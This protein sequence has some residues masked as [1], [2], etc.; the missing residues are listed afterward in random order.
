MPARKVNGLSEIIKNWELLCFDNFI[1]S[2]TYDKI[3]EKVLIVLR[4]NFW[5][6][7]TLLFLAIIFT[8]KC[9][10]KFHKLK[11]LGCEI[12]LI[13]KK[14]KSDEFNLKLIMKKILSLKINNIMVEA[15]GIFFTK[16]LENK[17]IDEIHIFKAPFNIGKTGK[18]MII[19]KKITDLPIKEISKNNFGKDVY[20]QFIFR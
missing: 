13:K 7:F 1:I 9:G 15:G 4:F 12:F 18:P 11:S 5:S 14:K 3:F 2:S 19:D 17:L 6:L 20:H 8:S 16:L 10:K